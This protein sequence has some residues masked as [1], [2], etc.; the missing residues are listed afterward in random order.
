M[1]TAP[2]R[3]TR[4]ATPHP[5]PDSN[6]L[7]PAAFEHELRELARSR[8]HDTHPFNVRMHQGGLSPAAL[9]TWVVNRFHYQR[10]IPVKDALILAKLPEAAMRRSWLRR[11]Q[12][13]DGLAEGEGGIERW[14]RLG[15]AVGVDRAEMESGES[16]LPGVRFAVDGYVNFCRLSPATEAVASSLTELCAPDIMLTRLETFPR[17][18]PWIEE[19]G[20]AYFRSRVPQGRRDGVEALTWVTAWARTR[21]EQLAALSALSF[22]CDILWS[23]LDA[24]EHGSRPGSAG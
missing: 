11:I 5:R 4:A 17:H 7:P 16:V 18:Y 8:Y 21:S 15:E 3:L 23:L 2:A 12:D 19:P 10:S 22:K 6:P 13:H 1:T 24:V 14:L 20:L 9:R